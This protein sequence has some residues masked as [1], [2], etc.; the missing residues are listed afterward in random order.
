M[1]TAYHEAGHAVMAWV[2][3][4]PIRLVSIRPTE[5]HAGCNRFDEIMEDIHDVNLAAIFVAGD[6]ADRIYSF[7]EVRFYGSRNQQTPRALGCSATDRGP[8][9]GRDGRLRR[10]RGSVSVIAGPRSR[11]SR[12]SSNTT[13]SCGATTSTAC[14]VRP[15]RAARRNNAASHSIPTTSTSTSQMA[16]R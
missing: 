14:A 7:R 2:H 3:S 10:K 13:H 5:E 1:T 12:A 6:I 9:W 16:D 11:R 4:V 8:H 15:V